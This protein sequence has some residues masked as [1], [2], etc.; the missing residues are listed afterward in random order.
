MKALEILRN[1]IRGSV[2]SVNYDIVDGSWYKTLAET[3][4]EPNI[5][6]LGSFEENHKYFAVYEHYVGE[7]FLLLM[8]SPDV[9]RKEERM[10]R[11]FWKIKDSF[12]DEP[13]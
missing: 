7:A 11:L 8:G 9:I 3:N 6:Y 5:K 2:L 13:R 12:C 1:L 4:D 10:N